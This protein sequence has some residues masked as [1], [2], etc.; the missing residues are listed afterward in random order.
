MATL[1]RLP[2]EKEGGK[3]SE[4][5]DAQKTCTSTRAQGRAINSGDFWTSGPLLGLTPAPGLE[6]ST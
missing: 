1:C 5:V 2:T 3:R 6:R 4:W